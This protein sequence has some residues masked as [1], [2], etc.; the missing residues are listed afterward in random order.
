MPVA[1]RVD[2][3]LCSVS[4]SSYPTNFICRSYRTPATK[5][6]DTDLKSQ[7]RGF[8]H[9]NSENLCSEKWRGFSSID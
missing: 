7:V 4:D 2:S 6:E 5:V 3:T 1:P 8:L 9:E